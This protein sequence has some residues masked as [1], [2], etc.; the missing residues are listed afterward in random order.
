MDIS[1]VLQ[2]LLLALMVA[3]FYASIGAGLS[4]VW[5]VTRIVNFAHGEFVMLG[6]YIT[7]FLYTTR[8]IHPLVGMVVATVAM[9]VLGSVVYRTFL[10]RVLKVPGHNQLLATMGLSIMLQSLAIIWWTPEARAMHVPDI[11][12]SLR[13][14]EV[15]LPGNNLL[16]GIVGIALYLLLVAVISRTTYGLHMRLACDD[17][18]LAVYTG[19]N[20]DRMFELSFIAG[21]SLAGA[22]G[23]LVALVLYVHP[24]VGLELAIK[25]FAIVALGGLGS[26]PGALAGALVLAVSEGLTATFISQGASW[27]YGVSFLLLVLVLILRPSGLFG[28]GALAR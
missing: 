17:P 28:K 8:G 11:L 22:S 16:V 18:E 10:T 25:A 2:S 19:V 4:L 13:L 24:L 1:A 6:G 20:V 5:G 9:G 15:V 3:A 12:P 26:I 23:A 21:C 7:L 27:G 14:G